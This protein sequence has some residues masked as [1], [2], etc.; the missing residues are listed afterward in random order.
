VLGFPFYLPQVLLLLLLLLLPL[1][2][3]ATAPFCPA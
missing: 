3:H 1:A 2:C